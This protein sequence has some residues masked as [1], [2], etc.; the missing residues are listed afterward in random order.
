MPEKLWETFQ[1]VADVMHWI[2]KYDLANALI[3][4]ARLVKALDID[5]LEKWQAWVEKQEK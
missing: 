5:T 4:A 2:G 3:M 1:K